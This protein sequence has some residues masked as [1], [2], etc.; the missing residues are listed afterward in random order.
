MKCNSPHLPPPPHLLPPSSSTTTSPLTSSSRHSDSISSSASSS[1]NMDLFHDRADVF[2]RF[3]IVTYEEEEIQFLTESVLVDEAEDEEDEDVDQRATPTAG[4]DSVSS[5]D[6][7]LRF[8]E[9]GDRILQKIRRHFSASSSAAERVAAGSVQLEKCIT[10]GVTLDRLMEMICERACAGCGLCARFL[11]TMDA[12]KREYA[13]E[14]LEK[15]G[16]K[17]KKKDGKKA[18]K[19]SRNARRESFLGILCPLLND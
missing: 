4:R 15:M 17:W 11:R 7:G 14:I 8:I 2:Y 1:L 19:E 12:D 18:R 9:D 16:H 10:K 3:T 13:K 6:A 5:V